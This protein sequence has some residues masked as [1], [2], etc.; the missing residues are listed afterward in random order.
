MQSNIIQPNLFIPGAAKSGTT[1]LHELLNVHPDITMSSVKEPVFW[2]S[3]SINVASKIEW[4]NSLFEDKNKRI[5]GESTT[6]YMYFDNFIPN[7]KS[8]Y[9]LNEPKF[10]FILRNPI[11]RLYSHY[12]WMVGRGQEKR[13]LKDAI[14]EDTN[15]NFEHYKAIPDYYFH[16]GLYSKWIANFYN[17]FKSENI[18]IITLEALIEDRIN[19]LNECFEFLGVSALNDVPDIVSNK[20]K[21]L[22][23]PKIHHFLKR[24]ASGKYT[25]TKFAK[26]IF[27]KSF[28]DNLKTQIKN[29][30][31]LAQGKPLE[32]PKISD[33]ERKEFYELYKD[34]VSQL[35]QLTKLS[36]SHW[37]DFK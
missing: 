27:P 24:M 22:R 28:I 9:G 2:N 19:T 14:I 5:L 32:Y 3:E 16:F 20:S 11:D 15:R 26:F 1:S 18:K 12:W 10:I 29:D 8:Y 34:D 36:F 31:F 35:K 37:E 33:E 6:S 21:S 23:Y 7:I 17:N 13:R 25:V 4:Y 30:K